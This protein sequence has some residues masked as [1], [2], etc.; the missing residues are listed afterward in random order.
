MTASAGCGAAAQEWSER[1]LELLTVTLQL[2]QRNGY[3]RLTLE[4]VAVE[5]RA[6]KATVYRRWPTKAELVLVAFIE[7]TRKTPIA[8]DAG[9]LRN[10]LLAVG[11]QICA[12]V[13]AHASTIQAVFVE[14]SRNA[15]LNAVLQRELVDQRKSLMSDVLDRAVNRGELER[16]AQYDDLWDLLPGYLLFR[17]ILTGRPPSSQ[18]VLCLVDEVLMP[19]LA[20]HAG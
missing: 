8:P 4:A 2:L 13:C 6:S 19:A 15:R 10:D 16:A 18:T 3:D 11:E 1:E 9:S 5:A 14:A 20:Q 12:H 7:G 17:A